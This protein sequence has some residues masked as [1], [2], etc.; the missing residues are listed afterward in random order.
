MVPK[1]IFSSEKK[2]RKKY[3]SNGT[4]EHI[5]SSNLQPSATSLTPISLQI[6]RENSYMVWGDRSSVVFFFKD[7]SETKSNPL[8]RENPKISPAALIKCYLKK[9][10]TELRS[11]KPYKSFLKSIVPKSIFSSEKKIRK[12]IFRM[13]LKNTPNPPIYSR[14]PPL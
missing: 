1:S 12:N 13:G 3:I 4:Q 6:Q 10:T 11:S 2:I 8:P 5:K 14:L 7:Q 9:N